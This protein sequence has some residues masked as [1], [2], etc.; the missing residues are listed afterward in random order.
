MT[1]TATT[2]KAENLAPKAVIIDS[3]KQLAQ[4]SPVALAMEYRGLAANDM[5]EL[6]RDA[7]AVG[8]TVRIAKNTLV[9]R[10]FHDTPYAS[11]G[12]GMTGPLMLLFSS[13]DNVSGAASIC[14]DYAGKHDF[15]QIRMLSLQGRQLDVSDTARI[16]A[17]PSHE[18]ALAQLLG[19]MLAPV[20]QFARLMK[21]PIV[22]L[23]AV[24]SEVRK[25]KEN[26]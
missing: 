24:L 13:D 14:K 25:Q 23:L 16:A 26:D 7:R 8:V 11:M 15:L 5:A 19:L 9:K 17:L 20:G 4:S 21:M 10:A 1:T 3:L 6:R 12:E 18:D 22:Q 2:V